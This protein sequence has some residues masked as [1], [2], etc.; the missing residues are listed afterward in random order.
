MW[1]KIVVFA[2]LVL[3][4]ASSAKGRYKIA[5]LDISNRKR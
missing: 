1:D 2:T 5:F 3:Q 4:C